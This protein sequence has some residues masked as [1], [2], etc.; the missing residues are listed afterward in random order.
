MIKKVLKNGSERANESN[1]Q[2]TEKLSSVPCFQTDNGRT[3]DGKRP[4]IN[5]RGNFHDDYRVF[6]SFELTI[7][8]DLAIKLI[9]E[10]KEFSTQD[11][12]YQQERYDELLSLYFRPMVDPERL[13][14]CL[15]KY[16]FSYDHIHRDILSFPEDN[17]RINSW[18]HIIE[19]DYSE[20]Y[21]FTPEFFERLDS[22]IKIDDFRPFVELGNK[23]V[24]FTDE[25]KTELIHVNYFTFLIKMVD[26]LRK[27][28]RTSYT[29]SGDE[30]WNFVDKNDQEDLSHPVDSCLEV[31]SFYELIDYDIITSKNNPIKYKVS[32]PNMEYYDSFF[33]ILSEKKSHN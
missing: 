17:L 30:L 12:N 27:N 20:I 3:F 28:D 4:V 9:H 10:V 8:Q 25:T 26:S 15:L 24:A 33:E 11:C 13:W 2:M 14:R 29:F 32:I 16:I 31:L 21:C 7:S 19:K 1:I 22:S 6:R 23:E 18:I 5:I